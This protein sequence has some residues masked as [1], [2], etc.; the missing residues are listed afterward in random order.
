MKK[1]KKIIISII[2]IIIVII[3]GLIINYYSNSTKIEKLIQNCDYIGAKQQIKINPM[4]SKSRIINLIKDTINNKYNI[5]KVDSISKFSNDTWKEIRNIKE[6]LGVIDYPITGDLIN[7]IDSIIS[8]EEYKDY[9]GIY[10]W[11]KNGELDKWQACLDVDSYDIQ[12]MTTW[13]SNLQKFSFS[14]YDTSDKYIMKLEKMKNRMINCSTRFV[15]AY[16]SQNESNFESAK[17]E[18]IDVLRENAD[19]EIE[20]ITICDE[21]DQ[22]LKNL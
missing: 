3:A 10:E 17:N 1:K 11:Y 20:I 4:Y 19:L 13:K 5:Q 6:L 7:S 22:K 9:V 21:L 14:E 18:L 8:L 12:T 16:N 15:N 2:T